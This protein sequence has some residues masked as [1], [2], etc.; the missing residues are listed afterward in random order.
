[1]YVKPVGRTVVSKNVP[2][3]LLFI[4][5]DWYLVYLDFLAEVRSVE[6]FVHRLLQPLRPT[7]IILSWL[8]L[9]GVR[10]SLGWA[11]GALN[12]I[13]WIVSWLLKPFVL[14]RDCVVY[15]LGLF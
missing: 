13:L 1:M 14:L 3:P 4:L 5:Q 9:Q 7:L 8:A 12:N 15:W 11:I 6:A 10:F 2:D